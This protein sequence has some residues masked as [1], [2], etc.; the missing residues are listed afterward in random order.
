VKRIVAASARP[1]LPTRM[2]NDTSSILTLLE[3]RRSAKPRELV[4]PAPSPD[5]L[6]RM[7]AIAARTPDHGKLHPWRFITVSAHQRDALA[8]LVRQALEEHDPDATAAHYEKE[9]EFAHYAGQLV[10]L[11]SAPVADHKIPVWEQELS[12][13]AA[14][15]N[16]LLA[17]HALGYVAGWVTGWRAYSERV[18][19]AFCGQGE[20][21]AGFIFIGHAGREMEDRARPALSDVWKNWVPPA[22]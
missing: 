4:G 15:M 17:A 20:R 2:L 14:G 12:C 9:N 7:L 8:E 1:Y 6:E 18:R 19:S 16:L 3:T 5:E 13:G 22:L 21:I 10:V 11:V